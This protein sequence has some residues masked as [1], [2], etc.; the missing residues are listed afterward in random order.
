MIENQS[1]MKN[2][3][4]TSWYERS[5]LRFV[6][7]AS[8]KLVIADLAVNKYYP[9]Q[10]GPVIQEWTKYICETQPLKNLF[11]PFLNTLIQII[12]SVFTYE[13]HV[14]QYFSRYKYI[15]QGVLT[16]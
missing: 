9:E 5:L 13:I 14:S 4:I 6:T 1:L 16:D 8:E 10:T 3:T 15:L 11:G 12:P 2:V 7:G